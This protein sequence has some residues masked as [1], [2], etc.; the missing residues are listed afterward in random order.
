M[1]GAAMAVLDKESGG[2]QF[3]AEG[4]TIPLRG[5]GEEARKAKSRLGSYYA[6]G[7]EG[8]RSLFAASDG[9]RSADLVQLKVLPTPP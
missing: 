5:S 2:P 1:G 6:K 9:P 3:G 7:P 8:R 4:L